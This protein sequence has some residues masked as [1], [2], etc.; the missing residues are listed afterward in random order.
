M[1]E[2]EEELPELEDDGEAVD[3]EDYD[4]EEEEEEEEPE[5]GPGS[6]AG[7][8]TADIEQPTAAVDVQPQ[9]GANQEEAR[10]AD[11]AAPTSREPPALRPAPGPAAQ[12]A[13]DKG[14]Q[15]AAQALSFDVSG[16]GGDD[17]AAQQEASSQP[18][19]AQSVRASVAKLQ[20]PR[21][22]PVKTPPARKRMPIPAPK[23]RE[24]VP[25]AD[26]KP[27][28]AT[29]P[30]PDEGRSARGWRDQAGAAPG[31][32]MH[33]QNGGAVAGAGVGLVRGMGGPMGGMPMLPLPLGMMQMMGMRPMMGAR[34]GTMGLM[35]HL[36]GQGLQGTGMGP[37]RPPPLRPPQQHGAALP[38][39]GV[40]MEEIGLGFGLR[41][42]G[43]GRGGGA[44][45]SGFSLAMGMDFEPRDVRAH[46][47]PDKLP[48]H[49]RGPAAMHVPGRMGPRPGGLVPP[50]LAGR[51][52]ALDMGPGGHLGAP[53]GVVFDHPGPNPSPVQLAEERRR[54]EE[55]QEAARAHAAEAE[56]RNEALMEL[57][58]QKARMQIEMQRLQN[59]V[60]AAKAAEALRTQGKDLE[61]ELDTLRSQ[62]ASL[63]KQ[64]AS[65]AAVL[66]AAAAPSPHAGRP[67]AAQALHADDEEMTVV[68]DAARPVEPAREREPEPPRRIARDP[69]AARLAPRHASPEVLE[70]V[71]GPAK[72][73][74]PMRGDPMRRAHPEL[75]ERED[76]VRDAERRPRR[77][78]H[79]D[80][81]RRRSSE[82]AVRSIEPEDEW[83]APAE[84]ADT[85]ATD[86]SP[87]R[88]R[89]R[90]PAARESEPM[91]EP[92][93]DARQ[94]IERKRA[95]IA[96]AEPHGRADAG[97]GGGPCAAAS[98]VGDPDDYDAGGGGTDERRRERPEFE[99]L[100]KARR[101]RLG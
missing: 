71:R 37:P 68:M 3:Y 25:A 74:D 26:P 90:Q 50:S 43:E 57:K 96:A 69:W 40:A 48:D 34:G 45:S 89:E 83:A 60:L 11:A 36:M 72:Q 2:L 49:V 100:Y 7:A 9:Q 23:P 99:R 56:K 52:G 54:R 58:L 75:S 65:K 27:Q 6:G 55:A 32:R 61:V 73:G 8:G 29:D 47:H 76:H 10:F 51:L 53:R 12:A 84:W 44:H 28:A 4:L 18:R 5:Q 78:V 77:A 17:A 16:D 67:A 81:D 79:A 31:G 70:V 94:L 85:P 98:R 42:P 66:P 14:R 88:V 46:G 13:Q 91:R 63:E 33:A 80:G 86:P 87:R 21:A 64:A 41:H 15:D 101:A 62:L 35:P 30:K 93:F 95:R 97:R 1:V 19:Q 38:S 22:E 82:R 20:R 59:K 39:E 92:A 24:G